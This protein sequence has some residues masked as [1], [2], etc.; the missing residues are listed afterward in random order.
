MQWKPPRSQVLIWLPSLLML[1]VLGCSPTSTLEPTTASIPTAIKTATVEQT[2]SSTPTRVTTPTETVT[3]TATIA[4]SQAPTESLSDAELVEILDQEIERIFDQSISPGLAVGVIKDN[5]LIYA[6][7]FGVTNLETGDEVTPRTLFH[8]ASITKPFVAT[9]IVQLYEQGKLS[10]DDPVVEHLPYFAINDERS[11]MLTIRQFLTHSSGMPDVDDYHWENPEYDEGA[12]ERYVRSISDKELLY[13]PG[14]QFSYS[15]LAFE[16]LGDMIAKVSGQSFADYVKENI[17]LPLGMNDS[18]I[19]IE[20]VDPALLA[21]GYIQ[22]DSGEV[23]ASEHF[24]YNRSHGPSSTL[25]SNVIDMSRWAI[26]N[27]NRGELDGTRILDE[28]SYEL[29]WEPSVMV[30]V[31]D[32]RRVRLGLSWFLSRFGGQQTVYHGGAD[33]GYRTNL[34]MVPDTGAAV[35]VLSNFFGL[36]SPVEDVTQLALELLVG[37]EWGQ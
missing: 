9:S 21:Y 16:V 11:D 19:L 14:R 10:L 3:G 8:M 23:L 6:R 32:G 20:D 22:G 7:G 26:A 5:E 18:S 31:R 13:E 30:G 37:P 33:I 27:M 24:A 4:P 12:L 17:L 1:S 34:V 35:I 36:D 2:P 25:H 29:L 28:S 15:N